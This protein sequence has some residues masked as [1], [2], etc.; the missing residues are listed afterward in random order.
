MSQLRRNV[1]AGV[2]RIH[3][4]W[5]EIHPEL[6]CTQNVTCVTRQPP[7][8]SSTTCMMTSWQREL[9]SEIN[10][11]HVPV[12][13]S[14]LNMHQSHGLHEI[15]QRRLSNEPLM[16][17]IISRQIRRRR[18]EF[19]FNYEIAKRDDRHKM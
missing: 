19:C 5:C 3:A 14:L 1:R 11:Y 4:A 6:S 16:T 8:R 17:Q 15:L 9:T 13:L 18:Y 2:A 12:S 10:R 7:S